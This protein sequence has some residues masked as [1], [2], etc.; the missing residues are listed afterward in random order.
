M[1]DV[2]DER[3]H[4]LDAVRG[5][6]LFLGLAFHAGLSFLPGDQVWLVMD[7]ARSTP[8]AWLT[9][10]LHIF[11]M[12]TFFLLAGFFGRLVL[13]RK[14]YGYF[15]RSRSKRILLP[16]L[17][18]WP[19]VTAAFIGLMA[20]LYRGKFGLTAEQLPPP[21]PPSIDTFPL[22]HLWFLY[23]LILFYV[24]ML[25]LRPVLALDRGERLRAFAGTAAAW[26]I[27]RGLLQVV[28]AVPVATALLCQQG[29][30][31]WFGVRTPDTGLL[32]NTPALVTYG[33]AFLL[34]WVLN[35]PGEPLSAMRSNWPANLLAAGAFTAICL[36]LLGG[37]A[38][39]GSD[40]T[41]VE[42]VGYAASYALAI[43][44]W[45]FG[46]IGAALTFLNGERRWVRYVADSSYWVYIVHLPIVFALQIAVMDLPWP[47]PA[48]Y[49]VI[50]GATLALTLASY[51]LLVRHSFVGSLLNGPRRKRS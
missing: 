2:G 29:W 23:V 16:L 38:T 10:V 21:P 28:L 49:A 6:A 1:S 18:F 39:G 7:Q 35:R 32:P 12:A 27:R 4:A 31:L 37:K 8:I 48:K 33:S 46:L 25:I 3:L 51:Q 45:T 41:G 43:W 11:R 40:I 24:A 13:Q 26:S 19:L 15:V 14:G 5:G 34:G 50:L 36:V 9:F 22:T 30:P 42:R 20:W 44:T 47:A 17:I